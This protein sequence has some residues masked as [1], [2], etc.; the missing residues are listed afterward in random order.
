[1][2]VCVCVG[3]AFFPR[4][5]QTNTPYSHRPLLPFPLLATPTDNKRY[6]AAVE[7]IQMIYSSEEPSAKLAAL[8]PEQ[9]A[10]PGAYGAVP[11]F[12]IRI[13]PVLGTMPALMPPVASPGSAAEASAT[14]AVEG[15]RALGV[16]YG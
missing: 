16:F 10:D 9:Q 1:M 12:R 15:R 8:T 11:N 3:A 4:V 2:Y 7:N 13:L 6:R 5:L 14:G